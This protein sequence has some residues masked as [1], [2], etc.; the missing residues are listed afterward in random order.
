MN[1][2]IILAGGKGT[3]VNAGIPKQFVEIF[4]KPV[5]I[6]TIEKFQN[7]P[8]ID[9][10]EIVCVENYIDRLKKMVKQYNLSKVQ[11]IVKGGMDFQHSVINGVLN[12]YGKISP[13]DIVLIHYAASPFVSAD[14]ISDGIRVAKEKGNSTSATPCFLLTGTNDDGKQSTQW[15]DR[16]KIMQLNSP[17][18]FRYE[19]VYQL[20][21]DAMNKNL[22]DK[23]EPHTTSLMYLL[24][25]TIYFSKGNQTNIKITTKE[26][27]DLF[28]GYVLMM[29]HRQK[30]SRLS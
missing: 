9:S 10:I 28:E 5:L 23:V 25:H 4:G 24:G 3:R 7:H 14:I 30:Q 19:Y 15:I 26:D 20:Y 17:Q 11:W 13:K 22:L 6:Y 2:A 12:L 27:L 1:T 29:Q 16:D 18:C 8:G 21:Q